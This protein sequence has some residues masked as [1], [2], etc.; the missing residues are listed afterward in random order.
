MIM[1]MISSINRTVI[2]STVNVY[3]KSLWAVWIANMYWERK[4]GCCKIRQYICNMQKITF[5]IEQFYILGHI[6]SPLTLTLN[7]PLTENVLH[8]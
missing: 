8:I 4:T 7:L 1:M 5:L 6:F 3:V 2:E